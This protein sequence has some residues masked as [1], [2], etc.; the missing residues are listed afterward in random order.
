MSRLLVIAALVTPA[1][2]CFAAIP[3]GGAET[4]DGWNAYKF[5]M[6]PDAARAV[7]GQTF[8]PYSPKNLMNENRGAMSAKKPV[9]LFALPWTL[10][11]FFNA[12][13][14]LDEITLENE[15]KSSRNDCEKTFLTGLAQ[16]E[17]SYGGFSTVNPQR[18]RNDADT[19]PTALEWRAQG[20]SH[21]QF[22]TVALAE[23]Y[24]FV[25]KAR[26]NSGGNTVDLTAS[27]SGK[28]DEKS[29]PCVTNMDYKGK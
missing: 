20:A 11:L 14:K 19:P 6:S 9:S 1:L 3:A 28:P 4:L 25:W 8:G 10:D 7:P 15:K 12:S 16:L 5:G 13:E 24:A 29:A 22:A 26:R 21:Y 23:E 27:W 17:K 18:N 2:C